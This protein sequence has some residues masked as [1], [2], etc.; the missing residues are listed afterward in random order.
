MIW[1]VVNLL[2]VALCGEA[3]AGEVLGQQ[4][5]DWTTVEKVTVHKG[6]GKFESFLQ[7]IFTVDEALRKFKASPIHNTFQANELLKNDSYLT[8]LTD[9]CL[10]DFIEMSN[11]EDVGIKD[12]AYYITKNYQAFSSF[13]NLD[14]T[15]LTL[16]VGSKRLIP[17]KDTNSLVK[18]A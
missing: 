12:I 7:T 14:L 17:I 1:V 8:P 10:Q 13:S 16:F 15:E 18:P 11:M 9:H 6:T 2:T 4:E 5:T 3:S